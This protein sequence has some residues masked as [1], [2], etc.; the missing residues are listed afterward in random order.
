M[1]DDGNLQ[2][3]GQ[4]NS[5]WTAA[6]NS[7]FVPTIQSGDANKSSGGA[8]QLAYTI[9]SGG[10]A[11]WHSNLNN[12]ALPADALLTA[13]VKGGNQKRATPFDSRTAQNGRRSRWTIYVT[14]NER[15]QLVQIP[16]SAFTTQGVNAAQVTGFEVVF[17]Y[18]TGS[19]AF[20][21]DN[22]RLGGQ[23]APP[24]GQPCL[25]PAQYGHELLGA[26][27]PQWH[28]LAHQQRRTVAPCP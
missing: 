13:W 1:F 15:W 7:T 28:G 23:G 24:G 25:A 17:E 16:L 10:Y 9:N 6:P 4:G 8:L 20:W 18:T 22:V 2:A 11:V 3:N 19:G 21:I 12:V 26:P 5:Y 14:L 27:Y